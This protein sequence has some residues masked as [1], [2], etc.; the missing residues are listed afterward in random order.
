LKLATYQDRLSIAVDR[1]KVQ[2][3]A[4]DWA[5]TLAVGPDEPDFQ[6]RIEQP[7]VLVAPGALE[8]LL[9]PGGDA[10]SLAPL[11]GL[12]HR[13]VSQAIAF[14]DGH[15]ELHLEGNYLLSV[16]SAE[17]Y[18]TWEVTGADGSRIV[19]IPGGDIAIWAGGEEKPYAAAD[20]R[21]PN[22]SPS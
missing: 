14:R 8:T 13:P 19:S 18:E 6:V 15:F 7:C 17:D 4:F 1:A 10:D 20:L 11:L 12:I 22:A 9:I 5:V 16:P 2:S 3:V 21:S